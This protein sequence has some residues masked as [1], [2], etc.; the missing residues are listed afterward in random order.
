MDIDFPLVLVLATFATG[1]VALADKL[2][3]S[4]K[5]MAVVAQVEQQGATPEQVQLASKEPWLIENS[6]GFFPVLCFCPVAC[7]CV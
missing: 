5:R 7:R 1:L 3:F 6:K 4:K 2:Y